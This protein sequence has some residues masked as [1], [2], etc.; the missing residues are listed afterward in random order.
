MHG[1]VRA[2]WEIDDHTL[3]HPDLTTL[4]A[5]GLRRE[6]VV[7]RA[8]IRRLT[9]EPVSFFCYPAG[10]YDAKVIAAV[11]TAGFLGATTENDGI[12]TRRGMFTLARLRVQR[13]EGLALF[14]KA[15]AG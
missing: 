14:A 1:L 5:A 4:D 2:G 13:G 6:I 8:V 3:T 11:R 12:A 15:L 7:S 10:R 9:V